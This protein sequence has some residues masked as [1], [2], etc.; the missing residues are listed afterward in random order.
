MQVK[1]KRPHTPAEESRVQMDS[2]MTIVSLAVLLLLSFSFL[3]LDHS[4]SGVLQ[5]IFDFITQAFG[6]VY[7]VYLFAVLV[8]LGGLAFS[9]AGRIRLGDGPPQYGDLSWFSMLFCACIGSSILYWGMIEWAY[10]MGSPPFGFAPMGREAAEIAVTYTMF[11]WGLTGWGTYCMA[12]VIIAYYFFV[13]RI[14]V[15]RISVS[16]R[17]R[18]G[19]RRKFWADFIDV[20][21]IIGLCS[22]VAVSVALGTPMVAQGLHAIFGI[23]VDTRTHVW[24]ALVW[25]VLFGACTV[26]GVDKGIK[27][28]SNINSVLALVFV[29]FLLCCGPT[30]FIVNN[31]VNSLG[32]MLQEFLRMSFS[33]E[34]LGN[35]FP[36]LWTVFYWAWWISYVPVMGLFIAKISRGRT[37]RQ[38]IFGTTVLGSM[39]CWLF[40]TVLGGYG[41]GLQLSGELDTVANLGTL[42][43]YGAMMALLQTLPM[44][45]LVIGIF[46]ILSFVFLATTCDSST[47]ILATITTRRI[48]TCQEPPKRSRLLWSVAIIIWPVILLVVGG[49]NVVKLCSMIGSIPLLFIFYRMIRG[50]LEELKQT[51]ANVPAVLP[52][53]EADYEDAAGNP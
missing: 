22:G 31:T 6:G 9:K 44:P 46:V 5:K 4:D 32:V 26:S 33:T 8:L 20:F 43:D 2:G 53:K 36:Q 15:F 41:L 25:A 35:G 21:V 52:G 37:I 16:C 13:K 49:L 29:A 11:H 23:P 50:F 10:Y 39:G 17:L 27:I 38:V 1:E 3:F 7:L 45:K 30:V 18:E 28:L 12:A 40:Q 19:P 34:P 14:P 24:I 47:Y 42:G 48:T 51:T